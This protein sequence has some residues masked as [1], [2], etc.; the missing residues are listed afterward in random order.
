MA[1]ELVDIPFIAEMNHCSTIT[2]DIRHFIQ[3][4]YLSS[5][6]RAP[7]RAGADCESPIQ[8]MPSR[9]PSYILFHPPHSPRTL[10]LPPSQTLHFFPLLLL[11]V[12]LSD[13][14][15]YLS[16]SAQ[17]PPRAGAGHEFNSYA[18]PTGQTQVSWLCAT[19]TASNLCEEGCTQASQDQYRS[20]PF[21]YVHM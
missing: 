12:V 20:K 15:K 21:G 10:A 13:S 3:H 6:A 7:P 4:T 19:G 17:A 18:Q 11:Y 8:G 14:Q 2:W 16:H 5:S 9:F 1:F